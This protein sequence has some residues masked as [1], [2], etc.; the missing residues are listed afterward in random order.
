MAEN[1]LAHHRDT[2]E[3][4]NEMNYLLRPGQPVEVAVNDNAVK[5]VIYKNQQAA[6]QL[7]E[8]LHRS[9]PPCSRLATRSSD[10]RPV[11]SKFQISLAR[12]LR[13]ASSHFGVRRF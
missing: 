1:F 12:I 13:D 11:V 4:A 8:S 7:C 3:L 10:R 6:K 2:E 5:A 9:S